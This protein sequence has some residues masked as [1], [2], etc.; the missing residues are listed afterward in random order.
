VLD[1][2]PNNLSALTIKGWIYL[3][4]PKPELQE[5]SLTFFETVLNEEEGGNKRFL[6]AM[7]GRAKVYEKM[8]NY[9]ASLEI[10]SETSVS[11][12]EFLPVLIEKSKVHIFNGDWELALET[13][14]TVLTEDKN[15]IEGFRIYIFYI[16]S[17]ESDPDL[18][19]EKINELL[20]A[21]KFSE[22]RN[23]QLYYNISRLFA[24]YCGRKKE[25]LQKTMQMIDL[26]IQ[27]RPEDSHFHAELGY[28][29]QMMGDYQAAYTSYQYAT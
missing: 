28:Q 23:A 5:K 15:S 29:K 9:N 16:L 26:A 24:R 27:M 4:T 11:H 10:L 8:K 22:P 6:E 25:I 19:I 13:I 20:D 3:S 17:R 14:Q 21:M 2:N 7:L 1:G 18:A 12:R